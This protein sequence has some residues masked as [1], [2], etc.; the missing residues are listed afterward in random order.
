VGNSYAAI[1]LAEGLLKRGI[2]VHPIIYPAVS[3]TMARLRFFVT[4]AHSEE[5]LRI[6]ADALA[7]ELAKLSLLPRAEAEAEATDALAGRASP[8]EVS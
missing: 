7:D 2:H 3:E 8:S 1:R 5:Q 4:A 6:T